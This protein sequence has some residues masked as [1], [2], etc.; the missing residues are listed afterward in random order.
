MDFHQ[1]KVFIEVAREK[2]FSRAAENIFLTQPT[3][4]VHIKAL[5]DEMGTQLLDRSQR[6]LQLTAAGKVLVRYAKQLLDIK[7]EAL[8]AIQKERRMIKGHLEI[9]SSSVP[10]AYLLP[11]LMRSFLESYPAVTFAVMLRDSRQVFEYVRDYSYDLGFVGEPAPPDG[12][13][14]IKLQQD[15]L[16]LIAAPG[17][18]L[19]GEKAV[20]PLFELDLKDGQNAA[21]LLKIPFV[22]RE[23]GS[24]TR[25]LFES[26]LEE[27]FGRNRVVLQVAAYLESQE[28][29]KEAVKAGLGVT[30]ISRRAVSEEL[31][32]GLIKGYR[33]AGLRLERNFYLIYHRDRV[34]S[35]LS[36][37]FLDHCAGFYQ[38]ADED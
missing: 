1:L 33:L 24:A 10:G 22:M 28:A 11:E 2:S 35:P 34:L 19:P 25:V 29:I 36:Q 23:P 38:S 12:L 15:E 13:G 37:A 14:Q 17:T 9:A 5:E 4:S 16:V 8:F 26:A 21:E 30:A 3:V 32:A 20:P 18:C 27:F 7:E 31:A 6:E